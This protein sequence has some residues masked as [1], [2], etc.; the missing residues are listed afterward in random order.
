MSNLGEP[1]PSDSDLA[2]ALSK[3]AVPSLSSGFAD[4]VMAR[5][6]GR[7]EPLPAARSKFASAPWSRARRVTVGAIVA[8]ALATT[9]AATGVLEQLPVSLPSA[10]EV[11][12]SIRGSESSEVGPE[13]G[14]VRPQPEPSAAIEHRVTI[15]GPIDTSEELEEAFSRI[16][17]VR[18]SRTDIRRSNMDQRIGREINRRR[19]QGLPAP[20]TQQ[21]QLLREM[22]EQR[23][24][25]RDARLDEHSDERRETL[26]ERI[27]AGEELSREDLIPPALRQDNEGRVIR[28]R[29]RQLRNLP[30][31]QRRAVIR[32]WRDRQQQQVDGPSADPVAEGSAGTEAEQGADQSGPEIQERDS[33]P[34]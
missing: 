19:E 3:D 6:E 7:A 26:R 4:R 11:W 28:D 27:E 24:E 21:E 10:G 22:I 20:N 16:D 34:E 17:R 9:A 2:G 29:L 25:L 23:R 15:E 33:N 30:P 32:R 18:E 1:I 31:E 12:A 13:V 14:E 8:G 5:T